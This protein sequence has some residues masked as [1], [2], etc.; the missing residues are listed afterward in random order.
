M[1]LPD[2]R[3]RATAPELLDLGVP[4]AEALASLADLRF[5][6]RWLG[7]RRS[8]RRA[9]ASHLRPGA[10]LLDVGCGSCDLL[11]FLAS[12]ADGPLLAVGLD[13]KALHLRA[14]HAHLR[15][16]VA[17]VRALPFR[18]GCFDVVTAS[19]FLHHFDA[20]ELPGLLRQLFA[21]AR[22][23]LVVSDLHRSL[24]PF[25]FGRAFFPVLFRSRVSVLDGLVSIRRGFL[26]GE[27]RAAF[28]AAGLASVRIRR[29]FPYRLVAVV[30]REARQPPGARA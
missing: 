14:A 6:N 4:E 25:L 13:V 2:L 20:P 9:V 29:R 23:A 18:P 1:V 30:E 11:E 10:G 7:N 12:R 3:A 5:V 17:D 8:L 16:V 22:R 19:L 21:L 28:A 15:R 24:V 26:P 27:L